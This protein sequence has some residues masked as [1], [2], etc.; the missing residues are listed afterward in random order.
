VKP[1]TLSSKIVVRLSFLRQCLKDE[2]SAINDTQERNIVW[3]Q[4]SAQMGRF[5]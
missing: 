4:L 2:V 5:I 3:F 1:E